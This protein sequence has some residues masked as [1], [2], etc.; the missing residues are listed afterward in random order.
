MTRGMTDYA[1]TRVYLSIYLW[2]TTLDV[3]GPT[4]SL[5]AAELANKYS[6]FRLSGSIGPKETVR[7]LHDWAIDRDL[8]RSDKERLVR[9]LSYHMM[10]HPSYPAMRAYAQH[11]H[12]L[13][14]KEQPDLLPSFE[15]WRADADRY[16]EGPPSV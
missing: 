15:P 14:L 2:D 11:C 10:H 6:G 5:V 9:A 12:A 16:I 4:S 8:G 3:D 13:W 1:A 7:V